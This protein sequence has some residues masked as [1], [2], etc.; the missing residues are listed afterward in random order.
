M[1]TFRPDRLLPHAHVQTGQVNVSMHTLRPDR[2][3]LQCSCYNRT[4]CCPVCTH[5]D[6]MG[7]YFGAH[8]HLDMTHYYPVWTCLQ[9]NCCPFNLYRTCSC[10]N[11][12][13]QTRH[14]MLLSKCL[15]RRGC[16]PLC[17]YLITL[18]SR[19]THLYKTSCC[20]MCTQTGHTALWMHTFRQD[21]MVSYIYTF[22]LDTLLSR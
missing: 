6:R 2:F 11:A 21:I 16:C 3:L 8:V 10:L 1:H 9:D 18:L 12:K 20:P 17:T 13:V 15:D 22:R 19:Y 7:C 4:C 14:D 5:L